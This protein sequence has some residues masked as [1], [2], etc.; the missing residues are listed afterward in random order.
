MITAPFP[1]PRAV[2]RH[3]PLLSRLTGC[4]EVFQFN[5]FIASLL[6]SFCLAGI[7]S[8]GPMAWGQSKPPGN[9]IPTDFT[10]SDQQ[11]VFA[12]AS[13]MHS[14]PELY[15]YLCKDQNG[16]EIV[17]PLKNATQNPGGKFPEKP[18]IVIPDIDLNRF[19]ALPQAKARKYLEDLCTQHNKRRAAGVVVAQGPAPHLM[20]G[21]GVAPGA[22]VPPDPKLMPKPPQPDPATKSK[23][24]SAYVELAKVLSNDYSLAG[25]DVVSKVLP[26]MMIAIEK[27]SSEPALQK[28][29]HHLVTYDQKTNSLL[30][31]A[32]QGRDQSLASA[33]AQLS[34]AE[35]G[36][37]THT[38]TY[39]YYDEGAGRWVQKSVQVDDNPTVAYLSMSQMLIAQGTSDD[40]IRNRIERQKF[41]MLQKAKAASWK[42]LLPAMADRFSGQVSSRPLVN[43]RFVPE[44]KPYDRSMLDNYW[45]TGLSEFFQ[46]KYLARNVSG[47]ELQHVT[48]AVDFHHFST[49]PQP[50]TRHVYYIPRWKQDE[51]VELSTILFPDLVG[52]GKRYYVPK[53]PDG[54]GMNAAPN[55][56]LPDMCGVVKL[57]FTVWANEGKQNATSISIPERL[58][59]I[60][61]VLIEGAE[62]TLASS[63]YPFEAASATSKS[64]TTKPKSSTNG[65]DSDKKGTPKPPASMEERARETLSLYLEPLLTE[66]PEGSP[67]AQRIRKILANPRDVREEIVQKRKTDLLAACRAGQRYLGNYSD[68]DHEIEMGLLFVDCD[69]AGQAIRVELFDPEKPSQTRPWGGFISHDPRNNS[70]FLYLVP[71]DKATEPTASARNGLQ[72]DPFSPD[73]TSFMLSLTKAAGFDGK[74]EYRESFDTPRFTVREPWRP[75]RVKPAAQEST[76]LAAATQ[77]V[78]ENP[79][80]KLPKPR[81]IITTRGPANDPTNPGRS[82]PTTPKGRSR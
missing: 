39:E 40:M 32:I 12:V 14:H 35:R 9:V 37:Y 58:L 69:P 70:E 82:N 21:G 10:P 29:A 24:Q 80:W 63:M 43:V 23:A 49:L 8:P 26:E 2:S 56:E 20:G 11:L 42:E 57:T 77:R 48:F 6:W 53:F 65:K 73:A 50:T 81:P 33:K 25:N 28:A 34:R 41:I 66:L 52:T 61:P 72:A 74:F 62:I 3:Q 45:P 22:Y 78:K 16:R 15:F 51:E 19:G 46:G 55:L 17:R 76:Q 59:K 7:W 54:R 4:F 47:K 31:K 44:E 1:S 30:D 71:L 38:E 60:V 68:R 13:A 79:Q 75:V 5:S 27:N 67:S 36:D 64:S 18:P